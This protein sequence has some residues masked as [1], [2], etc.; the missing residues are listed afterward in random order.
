M[1]NKS[2]RTVTVL[3]IGPIDEHQVELA[4]FL[5][6]SEWALCPDTRWTIESC[7]SLRTAV[8]MLQDGHVS[9]VLY[10]KETEPLRWAETVDRVLQMPNA[11]YLIVT[12]RLADD[13]LWSEALNLGAY[14][15]LGKPFDRA[16]VIRT[17]SLAWLRWADRGAPP[18]TA[19]KRAI[20]M[21]LRAGC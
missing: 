15:V 17:L 10:D 13:R 3:S 5:S 19:P 18:I 20:G 7:S 16:E 8:P 1:V 12:S 14:D 9:I 21:P 11:P 2:Y 6:A 4:E